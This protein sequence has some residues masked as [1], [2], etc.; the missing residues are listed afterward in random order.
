MPAWVVVYVAMFG[1]TVAGQVVGML[2]DAL[3]LGRRVLWVPLACSLLFEAIA[4]A[5][6]G[7]PANASASARLSA[8]YSLV[9][10][11]VSLPLAAWT[12]VYK[13]YDLAVVLAFT[14][15][16]LFAGAFARWG[17]LALFAPRAS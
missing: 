10:G 5:R 1:G 4:G 14:L 11:A 6:V 9:L 15:G 13:S 7:R 16:V 12:A 2:L 3:L 17:L 8:R